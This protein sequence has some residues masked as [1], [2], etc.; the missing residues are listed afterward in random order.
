ME[1]N[2][3]GVKLIF[4][5]LLFGKQICISG[6][7]NANHRRNG[8]ERM[9]IEPKTPPNE[10][11]NGLFTACMVVGILGGIILGFK[12]YNSIVSR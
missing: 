4:S 11:L 9:T 3:G 6:D 10:L 8:G 5:F 12:L 7:T 2:I 1:V